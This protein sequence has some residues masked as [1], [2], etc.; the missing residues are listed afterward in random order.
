MSQQKL[1][2]V[3]GGGPGW[4]DQR[5]HPSGTLEKRDTI[6]CG[7]GALHAKIKERDTPSKRSLGNRSVQY[8]CSAI[9]AVEEM[10]DKKKSRLAL[11]TAEC[12]KWQTVAKGGR[13][14][15]AAAYELHGRRMRAVLQQLG[16][17]DVPPAKLKCIYNTAIRSDNGELAHINNMEVELLKWIEEETDLGPIVVTDIQ[18][19]A[20]LHK[21][22]DL[23]R[24]MK[25]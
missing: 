10:L 13:D 14:K 15:Q 2:A 21:S 5:P 11:L 7:K 16:V 1:Q 23:R 24:R 18:P 3:L 19:N 6:P 9:P 12:Q 20:L 4:V 25:T 17:N 8:I 22:R